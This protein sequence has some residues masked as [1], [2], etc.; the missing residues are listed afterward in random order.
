M[1]ERSRIASRPVMLEMMSS[2]RSCRADVALRA[3]FQ[4]QPLLPQFAREI[5]DARRAQRRDGAVRLAVGQVDHGQARRHLRPR[6]TLEPLVD[7]VLQQLG[8]LVEQVDRDQPLGQTPDHLVAAP[9]DRRQL[10]VFVEHA[11]R[12][13]RLHVLALGA[14]IELREQRRRPRPGPAATVPNWAAAASRSSPRPRI[15]SSARY[16]HRSAPSVAAS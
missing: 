10:A 14:E 15:P 5:G 12:V 16:R 1:S 2:A 6:R 9:A 4:Q 13:D 3:R 11:E 7:L 8:R